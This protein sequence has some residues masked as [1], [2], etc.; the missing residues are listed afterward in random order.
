MRILIADDHAVVRSGLRAILGK[1]EGWEVCAEAETGHEALELAKRLRPDVVTM[2][3]SMPGTSGLEAA[4]AI[5]KGVPGAEVI[6]LTCHYSKALLREVM[7]LG[8]LGFVLK[9]DAERD[10]IA[11]VEAVRRRQRYISRPPDATLAVS[12]RS[13]FL[14]SLLAD[15]DPLTRGEREEVRLI[16]DRM[17]QIL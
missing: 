4:A 12:S 1:R 10:L 6:V 15:D 7:R 5:K 16:A 13:D 3:L 9:S 11:A 14:G 17:R 8:V 2:D